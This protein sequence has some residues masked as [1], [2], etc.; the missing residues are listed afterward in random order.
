[1]FRRTVLVGWEVSGLV[2][3]GGFQC[4]SIFHSRSSQAPLVGLWEE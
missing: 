4:R 2:Y 3:G 1:M